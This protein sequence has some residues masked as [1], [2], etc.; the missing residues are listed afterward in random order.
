MSCLGGTFARA[1]DFTA[2]VVDIASIESIPTLLDV[3]C[4]TTGMGFVAVARVTEY[5]W[6]ACALRDDIAFGLKPGGELKAATTI[7]HQIRQSQSAV[8]IDHVAVDPIYRGHLT[9]ALYGFQ[10]YIATP[11]IIPGGTF[12][13]TLCA[14][15][16][17]PARVSKPEV[18]GMFKLFAELIAFHLDARRRGA[19]GTVHPDR[20]RL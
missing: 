6:I 14:I 5:R 2:D 16:P 10:S 9:P 7:C 17:K 3:I 20:T 19:V 12:F 18:I 11:I 8:A 1:H 4:R 13:G 15:D